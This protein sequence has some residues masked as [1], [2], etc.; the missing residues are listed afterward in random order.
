MSIQIIGM[1]MTACSAGYGPSQNMV[2]K[3]STESGLQRQELIGYIDKP[4]CKSR[5]WETRE[6]RS[7][8]VKQETFYSK[9]IQRDI[10]YHITLPPTYNKESKSEYP[11]LYW[12][13]GSGGSL[14]GI[15]YLSKM[16]YKLMKNENLEEMII[17]YPNGLANGMWVD[18][19]D[20]CTPIESII[21]RELIPHINQTY[22]VSRDRE[23]TTIEGHSMGG[24][25]ALR[26]GFKYPQIFGKVSA[27][28][29]GPLQDDLF[30]G[31]QDYIAGLRVRQQVFKNVYG[32]S[33]TYY[34]QTSPLALA[35]KYAKLNREDRNSK[36]RI[37]IG[38]EDEGY[39][40][41]ISF[42]KEL[43]II[44]LEHDL[45]ELEGVEHAPTDALRELSSGN[46][47]RKWLGFYK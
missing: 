11:V 10:S 38:T 42:H 32:S 41:T 22:R 35:R 3:A 39:E 16:F 18:S 30:E 24:Y 36:I 46:A 5:M 9:L 43:E 37:I 2:R 4:N 25:G 28:G 47:R 26:L 8:Q 40:A 29:P 21:I 23:K 45:I 12:L 33:A 13:H 15:V 17:I 20:G 6:A 31:D 34:I 19:K 44:N 14:R 1:V 27:I 7:E